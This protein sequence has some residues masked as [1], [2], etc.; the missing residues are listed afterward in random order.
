MNLINIDC[1][2]EDP[3]Q[4]AKEDRDSALRQKTEIAW[5][6]MGDEN[7]N[8]FHQSIKRKHSFNTIN[9]LHMGNDIISDH[10]RIKEIFQK[11]YMDL[12]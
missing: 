3:L 9:V 11:Y 12:L 6:T 5:V 8:F 2:L 1:K 10:T 7:N 4:K